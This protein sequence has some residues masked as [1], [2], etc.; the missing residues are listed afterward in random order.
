M[1]PAAAAITTDPVR[2]RGRHVNF[3]FSQEPS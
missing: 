3:R 2:G 1:L